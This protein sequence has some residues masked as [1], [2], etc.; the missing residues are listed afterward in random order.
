MR[1]SWLKF[2][3][4]WLL[5][6]LS[7]IFLWPLSLLFARV[8]AVRNRLYNTAA[9]EIIRVDKPVISIGNLTLGGTGKTPMTSFLLEVLAERG[10]RCAVVSR[11]YRGKQGRTSPARVT[12][13]GSEEAARQ[14][15]DE[16]AWLA[17]R[18]KTVPVY[19]GAD[20]V[21]AAQLLATENPEVQVILADD[22]FQHRRLHRD[23][24][25]VL[26]DAS[27]SL[28][29]Y[30]LLPLGRMRESLVALERANFVFITKAN[31]A[32]EAKLAWLRRTLNQQRTGSNFKVIEF[33]SVIG[34][35]SRLEDF[36]LSPQP[37]EATLRGLRVVLVS[38]IARPKTFS[39][40]VEAFAV[41]IIFHRIFADHHVYSPSDL[42]G[43]EEMAEELQADAV[44]VTE[45]DGVKLSEWRPKR[46]L[47]VLVSRLALR[48]L[49][50]LHG[51]FEEASRL[52]R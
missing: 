46:Q 39:R 43:I 27:E 28:S 47:Q 24:D 33:E 37:R 14:F 6:S 18:H 42:E 16:P 52:T 26:L 23:T 9:L 17:F 25:I 34:G 32:S 41:E 12:A 7:A 51:F 11:G 13:D 10:V 8:V 50:S 35:F 45:K 44:I 19:V 21:R 15:G 29:H 38:G 1:L 48:P 3:A 36:H 20:R 4:K 2:I 40:L 22:A 30:R 31:L 49:G 5:A